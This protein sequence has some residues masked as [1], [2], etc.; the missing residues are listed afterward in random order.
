MS[1]AFFNCIQFI[2]INVTN[3][4]KKS[5]VCHFLTCQLMKKAYNRNL[6]SHVHKAAG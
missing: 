3:S 1:E 4:A 5:M 2:P 6:E